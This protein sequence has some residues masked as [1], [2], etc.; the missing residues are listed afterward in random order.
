[1]KFIITVL[2][3]TLL[4]Y[5][6]QAQ[7]QLETLTVEKIMRDPKWIGSSPSQLQWNAS[8]DSLFFLWNPT[9]ADGDSIIL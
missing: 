3:S 5:C 9:Q 6:T 1:M 8:S 2:T 4:F 7:M